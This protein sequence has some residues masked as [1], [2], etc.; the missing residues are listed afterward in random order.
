[1]KQPISKK[2]LEDKKRASVGLPTAA[3]VAAELGAVN[4]SAAASPAQLELL[5][6]IAVSLRGIDE[7]LRSLID[8]A[9]ERIAAPPEAETDKSKSKPK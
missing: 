6:S 7:S 4:G 9:K 1:M 8:A 3:Q 2:D 5:Q